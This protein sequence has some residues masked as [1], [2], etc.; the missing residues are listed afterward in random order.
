M[1]AV[2][3]HCHLDILARSDPSA[4]SWYRTRGVVAI[5]WSY[6]EG[7]PS[8][9]R[10]PAYWDH[11]AALCR[12]AER[13][14]ARC[15]YM[16]GIHPR[17]IPLDLAEEDTFPS[18]LRDVFAAHL[19]NPHC[20]GLGELGMDS[21]SRG[22]EKVLRWQLEWAEEHLPPAKRLGLHTPRQHKESMTERLL[23]LLEH[24]RPLIPSLVIDHVTPVTFTMVCEMGCAVGITLQEGKS[25]GDDVRALLT[26]KRSELVGTTMV[27]SDSAVRLSQPYTRWI[28]EGDGILEKEVYTALT[29]RNAAR[30]FHLDKEDGTPCNKTA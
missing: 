1:H 17:S 9:H 23:R 29:W 15:F 26:M 20:L 8:Y 13:K 21:G 5:T 10:Y 14:G 19:T 3:A 11:L 12:E 4:L 28:D 22:E 7:I 27:N 6:Y 25:D 18:L 30:F 16:V 24:H 2:D